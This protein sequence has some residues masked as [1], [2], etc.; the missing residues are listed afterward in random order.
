M[1][2]FCYNNHIKYGYDDNLDYEFRKN[3]DQKYSLKFSKAQQTILTYKEECIRTARLIKEA[4]GS[5]TIWISYS[6]GIDSECVIKSFLEA[7][8]DFKVVT[9]KFKGEL[10]D[11][12][13][14]YARKFCREHGV[15][16]TEIEIDIE[17]FLENELEEYAFK[18]NCNSPI[19]PSHLKLWDSLDG[20]IV[21]GHGDPIF[22]RIESTNNW[23]FQVKE[24]E[25]T[26]YRY[27][28]WRNRT[29]A[30]GFYAYTPEMILSFMYTDE[31]GRLMTF[32]HSAKVAGITGT[33]EIILQ[34]IFNTEKRH[35]STGFEKINHL[36]KYY[37]AKLEDK[38][39]TTIWTQP[40]PNLIKALYPDSMVGSS[41]GTPHLPQVYR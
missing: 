24:N 8:I 33:K 28:K 12:D 17:H 18:L 22:R 27:F 1:I 31:F 6:G 10:N 4:A 23:Y 20:F 21:A 13:L 32:G 9:T 37:R 29:G 3:K 26:V 40:V 7:G 34:K 5:Q 35:G 14:Y 11:Y 2:E 39:K 15:D 25:D 41:K 38:I 30:P 36:D 16:L 19:F